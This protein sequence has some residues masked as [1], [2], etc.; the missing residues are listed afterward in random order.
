MTHQERCEPL[1]KA[2]NRSQAPKLRHWIS[3]VRT[4]LVWIVASAGL[5]P[6]NAT[7]TQSDAGY[8]PIISGGAGY[9]HNVRGGGPTLEPQV[10]PVLLVPFGR[11]VLLES[12]TDFSGFFERQNFTS[13]PFIGKVFKDVEYA[14]L[15][16]LADTNAIVTGG[17]YLLPFRLYNERLEPVWIRNLQDFPYTASIGT[18]TTGAGDGIMLRGVAAQTPELSLQYSA[19]FSVHSNINQLSSAR[20]AGGDASVYFPRLRFEFGGSGQ[21]FLEDR[22]IY[23]SAAY[24]SWQPPEASL[25][26]KAELDYSFF[27]CGYW[28]EAAYRL[29]HASPYAAIHKVQLVGRIEQV[30]PLHGGGNGLPHI[31][32]KRFDFGLNYYLK[33]NLRLVSSYGRNFSSRQNL[34]VWNAGITYRFTIP[35]WFKEER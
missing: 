12:R 35:L 19:Y 21:R 3:F 15:D 24:V 32:N 34:N 11:H 6:Q 27:G 7:D 10:D 29:D 8:V 31:E 13:G 20:T 18:R 2:N 33:D 4:L 30:A 16:W 26:M 9:V 28:L 23:S 5:F 22:R 14:Q 25:D 17:R 1:M